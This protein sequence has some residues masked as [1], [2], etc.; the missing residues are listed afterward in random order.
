MIS[1]IR[2][3]AFGESPQAVAS[4]FEIMVA[5]LQALPINDHADPVMPGECV[6]ERDLNEP[7]DTR[8]AWKGRLV[9]HPNVAPH[10][11]GERG[12]GIDNPGEMVSP[13]PPQG[14]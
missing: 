5:V 10:D 11:A 6:I 2:L 9:L 7:D 14:T 3:D 8:H 1:R 13:T 4:T 12:R